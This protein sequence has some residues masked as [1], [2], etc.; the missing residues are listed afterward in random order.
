MTPNLLVAG[1]TLFRPHR[2]FSGRKS[3]KPIRKSEHWDEP[4]AGTYEY[5][6]GR[7][8]YLVSPDSMNGEKLAQPLHVKY[9]SVLKR[10]ML[11][12][13]Y[14][15]RR[16]PHGKY[17]DSNG[18][19]REA[20]FFRLDDDTSYVKCWD[21]NGEFIPGPWERWCVDKTS[22]K[23]RKMLKGD[24]PEWQSRHS[25]RSN[26]VTAPVSMRDGLSLPSTRPSS[27]RG[28]SGSRSVPTSRPSSPP[29]SQIEAGMAVSQPNTRPNS[30]RQHSSTHGTRLKP[31][32]PTDSAR[33]VN[34]SVAAEKIPKGTLEKLS[35]T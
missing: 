33:D 26:S 21:N 31:I 12:R 25:S 27:A 32:T 7:G 9:S 22:S 10:H 23:F 8:W 15:E 5:I 18:K 34:A 19:P 35:D 1:T 6:P 20:G 4:V 28:I 16:V 11:H 30:I 2:W 17:I 24:D 13:D 3:D 29:R 14:D